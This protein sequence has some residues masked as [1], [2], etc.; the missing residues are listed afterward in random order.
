MTNRYSIDIYRT[1]DAILIHDRPGGWKRAILGLL[2]SVAVLFLFIV[3]CLA[4]YF[5]P[6]QR[7]AQDPVFTTTI[8]LIFCGF[9]FIPLFMLGIASFV[10]LFFFSHWRIGGHETILIDRN[11]IRYDWW[12]FWGRRSRILPRPEKIQTETIPGSGI[13]GGNFGVKMH[14][15]KRQKWF[16][17][18]KIKKYLPT[19]SERKWLFDE[20]A[21]FQQEVPVT[22]P[23][24]ETRPVKKGSYSDPDYGENLLDTLELYGK[25]LVHV[26]PGNES[27]TFDESTDHLPSGVLQVRCVKCHRIVPHDHVSQ[28]RLI[29]KCPHCNAVFQLS[30]LERTE[31]SVKSRLHIRRDDDSLEIV[32]RPLRTGMPLIMVTLFLLMDAVCIAFY[33]WLQQ[34]FPG[35]DPLMLLRGEDNPDIMVGYQLVMML[36]VMH[37]VLLFLPL[38]TMFD[39]RTIWIDRETL[40]IIGSWLFVFRWK[41]TIP[42]IF[43]KRARSR[44][45]ETLFCQ[46]RIC[47]GGKSVYIG[48]STEEEVAA[49]C[50]EINHFLYTVPP[51]L[52]EHLVFPP[53]KPAFVGGVDSGSPEVGVHCPGCG[54]QY[55]ASSLD[56]PQQAAHCSCCQ[57]R[58]SLEHVV[59]YPINVVENKPSDGLIVEKTDNCLSIQYSRHI[60][61]AMKYVNLVGFCCCMIIFGGLMFALI[62]I[63]LTDEKMSTFGR[64][65][66]LIIFVLPMSTMILWIFFKLFQEKNAMY[67]D[68]AIHVTR[69]EVTLEH[70]YRKQERT[71]VIPREK[72][73]RVELNREHVSVS[74]MFR[75][76][77]YP[78]G[79]F[80]NR[81][82]CGCHILL[83]DGTK[84]YL[85]LLSLN[86]RK[87]HDTTRWL[88]AML[89]EFLATHPG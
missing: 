36:A 44:S 86:T 37:V 40:Q 43:V 65:A 24:D 32:Q 38:W 2:L 30:E 67:C 83:T 15:G 84:Q 85:P 18:R 77:T 6:P 50:A 23:V 4:F 89:N 13:I 27:A 12:Y 76:G 53:P 26:V 8:L 52:M 42:R 14:L 87:T 68:W 3:F 20:I 1:D 25:R 17:T 11:S 5:E 34:L 58:T 55:P 63:L 49:I 16:G 74:V 59:S 48:C 56:F 72:I 70:R 9:V 82:P 33:L 73:V 39:R 47:Y 41:R 62:Y 10:W 46:A 45:W 19:S 57:K 28:T 22:Q 21:K 66:M 7:A 31:L 64:Y 79:F 80:E 69:R 29:A 75:P 78:A 51:W 35:E 88:A 81:E 71:I 60:D 61:K 54:T